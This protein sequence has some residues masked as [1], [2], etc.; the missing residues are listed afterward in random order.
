[1]FFL[2]KYPFYT[3]ALPLFLPRK[4]LIYTSQIHI[5]K[6]VKIP[7]LHKS[8]KLGIFSLLNKRQTLANI[9]YCNSYIYIAD[10]YTRHY[11]KK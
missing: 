8:L 4:I 2:S 3:S 6:Q 11:I 5:F 1:M 10:I 7:S 9:L